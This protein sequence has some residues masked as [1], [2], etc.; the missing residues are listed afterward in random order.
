MTR[1]RTHAE[2]NR[3]RR[4]KLID[5]TLKSLAERGVAGTSVRTICG[6][7]AGSRSLIGHYFQGKEELLAVSFEEL[8]ARVTGAIKAAQARCGD[9]PRSQL[10]ALPRTM[11]S[12][13][14]FTPVHRNAFLSFWH[15]I[16]FNEAVRKTNQAMYSDYIEDVTRLFEAAAKKGEQSLDA[17]STA[18]GL[19]ALMDGLWLQMSINE[20]SLA[21]NRAIS[22]CIDYIDSHLAIEPSKRLAAEI[23]PLG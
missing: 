17:R 15:E 18:L 7:D 13:A 6:G 23:E 3:Y 10:M 11:F 20:K 14:V 16:R 1:P 8:L 2:I 21:R 22:L 19:V 12:S 4:R 9:D 5:A